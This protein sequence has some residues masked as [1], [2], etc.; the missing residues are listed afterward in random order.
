MLRTGALLLA[1]A[2]STNVEAQA[3]R[4]R[5]PIESFTSAQGIANDSITTITTDSRGFV[6]FGTLDGLSRYDGDRF[7]NYTTDD[8]LPDRMIF[9]FAEDR[10]GDVWIGTTSGAAP[11]G[12]PATRGPR[13]FSK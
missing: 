1:V 11:M 6:W 7:V 4:G 13:L 2:L 3:V 5:L 10:K 8:G 9:S 12:T